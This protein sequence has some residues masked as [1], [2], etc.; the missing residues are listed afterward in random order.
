M[1]LMLMLM[2]MLMA[3]AETEGGGG[4]G[5]G[6]T[7]A[8]EKERRTSAA[9]RAPAE[10]IPTP[11]GP[12]IGA[13]QAQRG[14]A[15]RRRP[16]RRRGKEGYAVVFTSKGSAGRFGP[17][18]ARAFWP[19]LR[20]VPCCGPGMMPFWWSWSRLFCPA[21]GETCG[22]MQHNSAKVGRLR[23][24]T[25]HEYASLKDHSHQFVHAA[26][27]GAPCLACFISRC[28]CNTFADLSGPNIQNWRAP[29]P[30]MERSRTGWSTAQSVDQM[31]KDM[32]G[33][34]MCI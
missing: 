14:W 22:E 5:G 29:K 13:G 17:F 9:Q 3:E 24:S 32:M 2:L 10:R 23:R 21:F 34:H 27:D 19:E 20:V 16:R 11:R 25:K 28:E 15:G 33:L 12:R 26:V 30:W 6:Y 18:V 1:L 7:G 31:D 8:F 4:G